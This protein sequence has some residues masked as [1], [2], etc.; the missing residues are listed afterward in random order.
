MDVITFDLHITQD[1]ERDA[2]IVMVETFDLE[3]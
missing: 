3:L 1:D 2:S